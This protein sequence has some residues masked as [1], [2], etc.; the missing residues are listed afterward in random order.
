M[1]G[2]T[3]P[4]QSRMV[5][6]LV[7]FNYT[8]GTADTLELKNPENWW[9]IEQDY[10]SD[11]FAFTTDAPRPIR[12]SL[13]TGEEI[14]ATYKYTSIKGFSNFAIDGGAATV[15]NFPLYPDK[16][17]KNMVLKAVANDVV[18]GLMSLTLEK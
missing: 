12:I 15:L 6:G 7:L 9:P 17:L 4:M 8:D 13:K 14:P 18:I 2:T 16:K 5:N 11:G 3:N 1:A 10:Y